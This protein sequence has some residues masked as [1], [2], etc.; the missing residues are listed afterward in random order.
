MR[1]SKE[2]AQRRAINW[3]LVMGALSNLPGIAWFIADGASLGA[4]IFMQVIFVIP[5]TAALTFALVMLV[6]SPQVSVYE[7]DSSADP[8]PKSSHS[9]QGVRSGL[10][11]AIIVIVSFCALIVGAG[12][13]DSAGKVLSWIA[14]PDDKQRKI[15]A[16]A[17]TLIRDLPR[18]LNKSIRLDRV[19]PGEDGQ[20]LVYHHTLVE[21]KAA[22]YDSNFKLRLEKD[23]R[24]AACTQRTSN[25]LRMDVSMEYHYRGSDGRPVHA[26]RV[27]PSDCR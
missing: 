5:A 11:E 7:K 27:S 24:T 1:L 26:F 13:G 19:H 20:S 22:R 4:A 12:L 8:Q 2:E 9:A 18:H 6:R 25:L 16:A 10:R 17:E 15:E 3:A 23:V 14:W 21:A